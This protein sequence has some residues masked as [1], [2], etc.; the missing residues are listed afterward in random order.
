MISGFTLGDIFSDLRVF[1]LKPFFREHSAFSLKTLCP[2]GTF[3]VY[4]RSLTNMQPL[5]GLNMP[6]YSGLVRGSGGPARRSGR[7]GHQRHGGHG[8]ICGL[9]VSASYAVKSLTVKTT[10]RRRQPA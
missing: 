6:G 8:G 3:V 7:Q 10:P 2:Y 5:R 9:C 1:V 4:D